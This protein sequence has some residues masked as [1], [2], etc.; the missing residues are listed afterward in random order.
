MPENLLADMYDSLKLPVIVCRKS[1]ALPVIFLNVAAKLLFAPNLSVEALRGNPRAGS[2]ASVMRFH[3]RENYHIFRSA[4]GDFDAVSDFETDILSFQG[5]I[6]PVR[7]HAN[8]VKTAGLS[9][10][11]IYADTGSGIGIG[12]E[13]DAWVMNHILD[14]SHRITDFDE[15]I[16]HVLKLAGSHTGVSR[17]YII[18]DKDPSTSGLTYEWCVEGVA[19]AADNLQDMDK[20]KYS[21]ETI[22]ST[23]GMVITNDTRLLPSGDRQILA[24]QGTL[25]IAVLPLYHYDTPLGFIGFD[26]CANNRK[27]AM[28][29]IR[30]LR[31]V[32]SVVSSL[33]NRRNA[34]RKGRRVQEIFRT[35]TDNLKELVFISDLNTH[36]LKFVSKSLVDLLGK[37][38]AELLGQPCWSAL[39][40]DY[41]GPC[42][43]CPVPGM[44]R[45]NEGG[46]RH[47]TWELQ[48]DI[49][50]KWYM[51]KNSIINWIDGDKVNLG[52]LVDITYRKQYEDQLKRVAAIDAMTDVY[53]RKWGYDKLQELFGVTTAVKERQTLCF[54]DLDGLK[55]VNDCLGHAAGD[56]MILNVIR[57]ILSCVRKD[58]FIA[59]WGGDEFVIFLNCRLVDA[60]NVLDKIQF[61]LEHF[62]ST[63]DKSYKLSISFGLV[64]FSEPWPNVDELIGEADRRMYEN[65][66]QKR[67]TE[68]RERKR[69]GKGRDSRLMTGKK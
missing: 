66:L 58:D 3:R 54:V 61:G 59:R 33:V 25:A 31:N 12:S 68:I 9:L 15:A 29:E 49:S 55:V 19:S 62:N 52:T 69:P 8:T 37:S 18:E 17:A 63:S 4:L 67:R 60:Q 32:A 38:E 22:M 48:H 34:E 2:L 28:E 42:P 20:A 7:L 10:F 23:A 56:E 57:T 51:A 11:I 50:N 43:Y 36:E 35:V 14:A 65:K 30:L 26:D 39:H 45:D 5:D 21:Y 53:N 40:P 46:G 24:S 27:W 16:R 6:I 13:T 47:V 1:A 64:D 41:K 44:L